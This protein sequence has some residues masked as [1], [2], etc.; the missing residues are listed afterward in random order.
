MKENEERGGRREQEEERKLRV[1]K[2]ELDRDSEWMGEIV[3]E[4][5]R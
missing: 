1:W 2:K 3:R 5:W 4:W